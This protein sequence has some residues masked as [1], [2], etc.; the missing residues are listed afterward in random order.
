MK[1][2]VLIMYSGPGS[3]HALFGGTSGKQYRATCPFFPQLVVDAE[4]E[5]QAMA[6]LRQRIKDSL[7]K[8]TTFAEVEI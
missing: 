1:I 2:P 3:S 4:T 7:G 5:M 8:D 6:G